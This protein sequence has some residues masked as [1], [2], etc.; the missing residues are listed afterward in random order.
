[1]GSGLEPMMQNATPPR[2]IRGSFPHLCP[3]YG[4]AVCQFVADSLTRKQ[5]EPPA[6]PKPIDTSR[7]LPRTA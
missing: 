3:G 6:L 7:P 2:L 1:M 5:L 4:C